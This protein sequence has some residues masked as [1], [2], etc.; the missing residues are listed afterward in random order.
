I[1]P[2]QAGLNTTTVGAS[3]RGGTRKQ[4]WNTHTT[5]KALSEDRAF[6]NQATVKPDQN[7][8]GRGSVAART[9]AGAKYKGL[10]Q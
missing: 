1:R 4:K 8:L 9:E 6:H 10:S 7:V 5:K 3:G 2:G